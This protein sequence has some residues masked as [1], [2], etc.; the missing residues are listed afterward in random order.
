MSCSPFPQED[1]M[2]SRFLLSMFTTLGALFSS[3][4][5]AQD[6]VNEVDATG[7]TSVATAEAACSAAVSSKMAKEAPFA[8][9]RRLLR[10]FI[11]VIAFV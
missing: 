8:S 11:C 5:D 1:E 10:V 3:T 9:P 6:A 4:I 2:A 7:T